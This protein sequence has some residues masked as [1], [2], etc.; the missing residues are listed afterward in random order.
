MDEPS[1]DL[2]VKR[3]ARL[4]ILDREGRMLL[5]RYHDEHRPPF[6]A[7]PGGRLESGETYLAAAARELREETG[8]HASVGPLLKTR[9]EVFPVA[10]SGID[11]YIEHYFLVETA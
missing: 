8:F 3:S 2:T 7:T 10:W 9:D 11:R 5:F 6:W 4:V 1:S